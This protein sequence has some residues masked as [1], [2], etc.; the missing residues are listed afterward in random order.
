MLPLLPLSLLVPCSGL[1]CLAFYLQN[2]HQSKRHIMR[3]V[4]QK[5]TDMQVPVPIDK[6]METGDLT[7]VVILRINSYKRFDEAAGNRVLGA[8]GG[9]HGIHAQLPKQPEGCHRDAN[10]CLLEW[11][12]PL[13]AST[14]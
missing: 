7:G 6:N 1:D 10:A 2:T 12:K 4:T 9:C 13:P 14:D 3:G 5:R 11:Q 8:R